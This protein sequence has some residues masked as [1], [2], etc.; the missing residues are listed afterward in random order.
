ML[1]QRHV[2]IRTSDSPR[3][4]TVSASCARGSRSLSRAIGG[5][6]SSQ[7][8]E[9]VDG[10]YIAAVLYVTMTAH[11][12]H[13]THTT[14]TQTHSHTHARKTDTMSGQSGASVA[15]LGTNPP[16]ATRAGVINMHVEG[17]CRSKFPDQN[18]VQYLAP[19][20]TRFLS[21]PL[22]SWP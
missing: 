18:V 20:Y 16:E 19:L 4:S 11:T 2:F 21:L 15:N 22:V 9:K 12:P 1:N 13:T 8:T 3:P 14:G 10:G 17:H 5:E 7:G 6:G